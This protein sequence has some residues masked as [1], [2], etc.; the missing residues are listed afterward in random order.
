MPSPHLPAAII[1]GCAPRWPGV[2]LSLLPRGQ[3]AH[4]AALLPSAP[5]RHRPP[6]LPSRGT[7]CSSQLFD[8]PHPRGQTTLERSRAHRLAPVSTTLF[9]TLAPTKRRPHQMHCLFME[10]GCLEDTLEE[11][12]SAAADHSFLKVFRSLSKLTRPWGFSSFIASY[13]VVSWLP[14]GSVSS[15]PR[16]F[17][18]E[19][20]STTCSLHPREEVFPSPH[21]A[22]NPGNCGEGRHSGQG[23]FY[24]LP[25]FLLSSFL[26]S[27]QIY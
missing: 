25:S 9:F 4:H 10:H 14:E 27:F 6:Q 12:C 21:R 16:S 8:S 5:P 24:F 3:R 19:K 2:V 11:L 15:T 22:P 23:E 1:S 17:S 26:S 20:A 7:Q 18:E 13:Y